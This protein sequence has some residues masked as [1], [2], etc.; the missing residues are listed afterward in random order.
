MNAPAPAP[1]IASRADFAEAVRWGVQT[2]V[3]QGARRIVC[4][5]AD[6]SLWPW[7]DVALLDALTAWLR[8]PQRQLVLLARHF[9]AMPQR[10][11]RFHRW[12]RDWVHAMAAW[13]PPADLATDLPTLLLGDTGVIVHLVDTV[14]IRGRAE[15]DRRRALVWREEIDVVLQRSEAAYG[16]STLGL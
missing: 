4:V 10:F 16:V 15:I 14:R 13:Q 7:D 3:A 6:F 2:A 11:P 9:D 5:D 1:A 12:R 8:Q